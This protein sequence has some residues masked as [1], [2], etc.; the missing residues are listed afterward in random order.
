MT[1]LAAGL[2]CQRAKPTGP[3]AADARARSGTRVTTEPLSAVDQPGA[4]DTSRTELSDYVVGPSLEMRR[5]EKPTV[6]PL[7]V[8]G[9]AAPRGPA[10]VG[11]IVDPAA[12]IEEQIRPPSE[13]VNGQGTAAA[14]AAT[15]A[16]ATRSVRVGASRGEYLT[17]GGVVAEVNGQPIYANK[18]L[19]AIEPKLAAMAR[20]MEAREFR[21]EASSEIA[22]KIVDFIENELEFAAAS[23]YLDAQEK[24][25]AQLLTEKWR[26]DQVNLAGGSEELARRRY[27]ERG[28]DF[29]ERVKEMYRVNMSR[30][31]YQKR[32]WPRVQVSAAE[33]RREYD[34]QLATKYTVHDRAKFRLI[35]IEPSKIGDPSVA[36]D[37][38]AELR[39]RAESEDFATLA[40]F[41]TDPVLA[42][43]GGLLPTPGGDGF[44]T[45]GTF[46][47]EDVE[48]AV[49]ALQPGEVTDVIDAGDAF[50]IAKLEAKESGKT[51]P[52]EAE[53]T[54]DEIRQTL[55][56][57]QFAERRQRMQ[58]KL[59]A[60]AVVRGDPRLDPQSMQIAVEIAMQ[61][62]PSWRGGATAA[63]TT[64]A[65]AE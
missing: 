33:M 64:P 50:Y 35:K 15:T 40:E 56:A 45:R 21:A 36:A 55:Q 3:F 2:G 9:H 53:S 58:E 27:R 19:A 39:T 22:Q 62:Y 31:F 42:R 60:D 29:D 26:Q 12:T 54:Q 13:S 63:A 16:P 61:R 4:V 20:N 49:W 24:E 65:A 30:L 10:A 11:S 17:I 14:A 57:Q 25:Y 41:S 51:I 8:G 6:R 44:F 7:A 32:V 18:V 5:N 52:F 28:E 43:N 59:M 48:A 34:R 47:V 1:A 23:R 38:A 46:A 37:R